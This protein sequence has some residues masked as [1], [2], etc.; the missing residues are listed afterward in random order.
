MQSLREPCSVL[1]KI[2]EYSWWY[3]PLDLASFVFDIWILNSNS[4]QTWDKYLKQAY[5]HSWGNDSDDLPYAKTNQ[6]YFVLDVIDI[7]LWKWSCLKCQNYIL[8]L[9]FNWII[10]VKGYDSLSVSLHLKFGNRI[11]CFVAL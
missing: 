7:I 2:C 1:M 11:T 8:E 10:L 4:G 5:K 9:I 3:N 6:T